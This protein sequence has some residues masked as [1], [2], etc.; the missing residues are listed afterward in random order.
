MTVYHV[1]EPIY[2]TWLTVFVCPDQADFLAEVER[3]F[4]YRIK[5][6]G[7]ISGLYYCFRNEDGAWRDL[8]WL[9]TLKPSDPDSL[10]ILV[11]EVYHYVAGVMTRLGI[12]PCVQAEEPYAYMMGFV[13][14]SLIT[15]AKKKKS[16]RK[17]R[18]T[19]S[20]E[21]VTIGA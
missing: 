18:F 4:N 12:P 13:V 8:L 20:R 21:A 17:P 3:R 19:K 14:N 11:H 15:A 6:Q 16:K 7:W 1:S 9:P 10:K 2:D 5:H